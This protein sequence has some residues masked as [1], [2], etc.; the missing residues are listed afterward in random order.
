MRHEYLK[1][2]FQKRKEI[3]S[4]LRDVLNSY[5]Q[6]KAIGSQVDES[7]L[8]KLQSMIEENQKRLSQLEAIL[9]N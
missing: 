2:E 9:G 6:L 4:S 3:V 8:K 1:D 5:H 7:R